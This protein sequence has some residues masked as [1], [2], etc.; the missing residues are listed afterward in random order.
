MSHLGQRPEL[1]EVTMYDVVVVGGGVAGLSAALILGRACRRVL[2]LDVG[3]PRNAPAQHAHGFLSRNGIEPLE[4]ARLAREELAAYESVEV[5]S[6]NAVDASVWSR[7]FS[8]ALAEGQRVEARKLVLATGVIDVLPQIPGLA[9]LWG[10]GLYHCPYCHG[11]EVRDRP[12]GVLG[13]AP[14][15]FERVALFRGWASEVV[16]LAN[17]ASRM[18]AAER[19]RLGKLGAVVDE[20][21]ILWVERAGQDDVNVRFEDGSSQRFG[22]VFAV[23][24]QVQRSPLAEELG[25]ELEE[26]GPTASSY[27][28]AD[29]TTGETTVSGVHA[30]G[31]MIGPMQSLILAAASGAR[32]AYMLNHAMA[33]EDVEA[34]LASAGSSAA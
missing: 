2:V 22:G 11:W 9:E 13:E 17:G 20:R 16:V 25:C 23:P 14:V 34:V 26:F 19:D 6:A 12:W 33:M 29:P 31:D 5:K 27:V 18:A 1:K 10:R 28:K 8:L 30:A 4:L 3:T 15:A 24:H 21:R 32:A 7:G